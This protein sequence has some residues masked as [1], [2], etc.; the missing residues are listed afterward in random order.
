M[1]GVKTADLPAHPGGK[2]RAIH[3]HYGVFPDESVRARVQKSGAIC[4]LTKP[5]DGET[6]IACLD[7]ALEG[8]GA[9]TGE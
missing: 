7:A 8:T 9:A 5:F 6:L 4:L 3:F 1:S 2:A